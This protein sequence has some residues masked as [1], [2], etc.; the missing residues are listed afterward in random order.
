MRMKTRAWGMGLSLSM[1]LGLGACFNPPSD[2]GITSN[3][4]GCTPGELDCECDAQ[5][6]C[7]AGLVCLDAVCVTSD[8]T[9]TSGATAVTT[10]VPSDE[11]ADATSS[12]TA[13]SDTTLAVDGTSTGDGTTGDAST[14]DSTTGEMTTDPGTST[15]MPEPAMETVSFPTAADP[16]VITSGTLP[17]NINDYFEGV[18]DTIVPSVSQLDVHI[19][20][21]SNGL[22][23]CGFQEAAVTLN[24]VSLGSF[25]VAQGTT[26][27]D[28]SFPVAGVVGP[29]YTIRYQTVAT[30]A[31][32]CGAAGYDEVSSTVTFWE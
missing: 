30:V 13:P 9:G 23:D 21:I 6:A 28:Q 8:A 10:E 29:Q 32:G 14:G 25:V 22:T 4:L 3:G 16:R 19:P 17:W 2:T 27:I 12:S 31:G 7:A 18:R 1:G 24:G 20:I 26:V 15:G 11:T 5:G